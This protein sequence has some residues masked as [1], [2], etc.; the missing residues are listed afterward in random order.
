MEFIPC[1]NVSGQSVGAIFLSKAQVLFAGPASVNG[2]RVKL[3]GSDTARWS[4]TLA[5]LQKLPA[6]RVVPGFGS[7]G[8]AAILE[9]QRLFLVE[10]RRQIAYKITMGMLAEGIE[11]HI[12]ISSSFLVWM[13]Y[14][15][16]TT[17]DIH[18]V[19][20]E[21]TIPGRSLSGAA[22]PEERPAASCPGL[23]R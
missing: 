3:H 12:V 18:S 11:K 14:D 22:S 13:P 21:S 8:S 2:P 19:Y 7:W 20:D 16:P 5:E 15:T 23:D 17:E 10:L 9:R 1:C 4:S 6:Q